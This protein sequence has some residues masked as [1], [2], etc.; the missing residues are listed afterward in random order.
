MK[1]FILLLP[2]VIYFLMLVINSVWSLAQRESLYHPTSRI[3]NML[4]I[5]S[6]SLGVNLF[7]KLTKIHTRADY[8]TQF[9][10]N[11]FSSF[12][13]VF[14]LVTGTDNRIWGGKVSIEL[15]SKVAVQS[16]YSV[17][18]FWI[19][20][21]YYFFEAVISLCLA[22]T[23]SFEKK[24]KTRLSSLHILSFSIAF[25]MFILLLARIII[26]FQ[27]Q[28]VPCWVKFDSPFLV[29]HVASVFTL[30]STGKYTLFL[31]LTQL[32][33]ILLGLSMG[34]S[35]LIFEILEVEKTLVWGNTETYS[36]LFQ[37]QTSIKLNNDSYRLKSMTGFELSFI[38][39]FVLK[40]HTF[41]IM[42]ELSVA[43]GTALFTAKFLEI[44]TN[45]NEIHD[46]AITEN[47]TFEEALSDNRKNL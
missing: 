9:I 4:D 7:Y 20:I 39:A 2:C 17:V 29:L 10:F 23:S 24:L 26:S 11:L 3:Y 38:E 46:G 40:T 34:V 36:I 30:F 12:L 31:H 41:Q 28:D 1:F 47:Q 14:T 43:F 32:F 19:G 25:S 44:T 45:L 8:I 42:N 18:L 16:V 21:F 13:C 27:Y 5:V 6:I 22:Y 15:T 33:L 35:F 37:N